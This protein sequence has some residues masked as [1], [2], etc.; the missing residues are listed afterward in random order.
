MHGR[1][2]AKFV[3]P[4]AGQAHADL[5]PIFFAA[6]AFDQTALGQTIHQADGAVVA[7]HQVFGKAADRGAVIIVERLDGEQQLVLLGLQTFISRGFL[8][9]M[10][11]A[12]DLVTKPGKSLVIDLHYLYRIT[13]LLL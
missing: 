6:Y 9:E 7:H 1:K 4:V 11:E 3:L 8:A 10:E 13:I 5:P 12:A 2:M